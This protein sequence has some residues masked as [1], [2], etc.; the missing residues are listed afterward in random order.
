MEVWRNAARLKLRRAGRT[1]SLNPFSLL[2]PQAT[3]HKPL[4]PR[5][6]GILFKRGSQIVNE[7]AK[8]AHVADWQ[9]FTRALREPD[10]YWDL[11]Y[12]L[13][14]SMLIVLVFWLAAWIAQAAITRSLEP[15]AEKE[16]HRHSYAQAARRRTFAALFCSLVRYGLYFFAFIFV[17]SAWNVR[18]LGVLGTALG[19][20]GILGVVVGFGAQKLVRD[21]FS[22]IFILAEDQYSVGDTVTIGAVTGV[23]SDVGI[24]I[25]RIRDEL[26]RLT[27]I[28]NGDIASVTN[29]SRGG[30]D[31]T[32]EVGVPVDQDLEVVRK[33][34]EAAGARLKDASES[35]VRGD[36]TIEG[37]TAMDA[38]KITLRVVVPATP[39]QQKRAEMA[40]RVAV[41]DE[42]LA[43]GVKIA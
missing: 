13:A 39:G 8:L 2:K 24:R 19:T 6:A 4:S 30:L 26:G 21:I 20:A 5:G 33:A 43:A 40:L 14:L 31:S 3:N 17:L 23:V 18:I 12:H 34:V 15:L 11:V 41:R 42:L 10:T 9:L 28:P 22:G 29:H 1:Y 27:M 16:H 37:V 36:A 35:L 32:I 7:T 25:T 38:T